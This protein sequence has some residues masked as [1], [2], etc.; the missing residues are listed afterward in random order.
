MSK[1]KNYFVG[2][3]KF[4]DNLTAA[5]LSGNNL[6]CTISAPASGA[7][8]MLGEINGSCDV[9]CTFTIEDGNATAKVIRKFRFENGGIVLLNSKDFDPTNDFA[10]A[11]EDLVVKFEG[12]ST[13]TNIF[14]NVTAYAFEG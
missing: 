2:A 4:T 6:T 8:L 5:D 12:D 14:L 7:P 1:D 9:S 13:P 3:T 11:G 10:R